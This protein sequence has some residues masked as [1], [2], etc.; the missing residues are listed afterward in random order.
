MA[1][2]RRT[3]HVAPV[4]EETYL[5]ERLVD[6]LRCHAG[7][8]AAVAL[9]LSRWI[10]PRRPSGRERVR[11]EAAE[12]YR[13]DA[14]AEPGLPPV[15]ADLQRVEQ[16]VVFISNALRYVPANGRDVARRAAGVWN[17]RNR[18][19]RRARSRPAQTVRP[20]LAQRKIARA[21]CGR[22]GAGAGY[23]SAAGGGAGWN[24]CRGQRAWR[25]IACVVRIVI[26]ARR[27]CW[28]ADTAS[29]SNEKMIFFTSLPARREV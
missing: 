3:T 29:L 12:G 9:I 1:C 28:A 10:W 5:L 14:R 2:I 21:R 27:C 19:N 16:V 24:P 20:F 26:I 23:C 25:G 11:A 15:N 22:R 7:R 8:V 6:D 17:W 4:L 18:R 13:A